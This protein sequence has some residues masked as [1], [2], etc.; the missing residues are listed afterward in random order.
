MEG[1]GRGKC[2]DFEGRKVIVYVDREEERTRGNPV[3]EFVL[4]E[5]RRWCQLC[6]HVHSSASELDQARPRSSSSVLVNT[7]DLIV[8]FNR[9]QTLFDARIHR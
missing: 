2:T 5:L 3:F 1:I 8:P 7:I 6:C 9:L 4:T